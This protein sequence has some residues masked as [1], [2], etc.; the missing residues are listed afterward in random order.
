MDT[1]N[2][3]KKMPKD[4]LGEILLGNNVLTAAKNYGARTFEKHG[5]MIES[6]GVAQIVKILFYSTDS[7]NFIGCISDRVAGKEP[8][9]AGKNAVVNLHAPLALERIDEVL[10]EMKAIV[11]NCCRRDAHV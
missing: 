5:R 11:Q 9:G 4:K 2:N 6:Q 3:D 8:W 1:S 7:D 10:A